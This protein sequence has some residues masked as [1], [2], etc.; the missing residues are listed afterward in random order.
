MP[1]TRAP[2]S[3]RSCAKSRSATTTSFG[4]RT[5]LPSVPKKPGSTAS[6]LY[7]PGASRLAKAPSVSNE[8]ESC[9]PAC[10]PRTNCPGPR[11]GFPPVVTRT[12]VH[13]GSPRSVPKSRRTTSPARAWNVSVR[14]SLALH[15][16]APRCATIQYGP[17][18][19]PPISYAP[20]APARVSQVIGKPRLP[21]HGFTCTTT[22]TAGLPSRS[23]TRPATPPSSR[24]STTRS[25]L[26]VGS[27]IR[28][29][30]SRVVAPSEAISRPCVA[31]RDA[32]DAKRPVR[33]DGDRGERFLSANVPEGALH[34][35]G[36]EPRVAAAVGA[37]PRHHHAFDSA[38]LDL[39]L[40]G[41]ECPRR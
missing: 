16:S 36:P 15:Q 33:C 20:S 35:V 1:D 29:L 34:V 26:T 23:N 5:R 22:P 10:P 31:G 21:P 37:R 9:A 11:T 27:G 6:T 39:G 2:G 18:E 17:G 25:V 13:S 40:E 24:A 4:I 19:R 32:I 8:V 41:P 3:T 38:A 7:V 28:K 30:T 14:S 12:P